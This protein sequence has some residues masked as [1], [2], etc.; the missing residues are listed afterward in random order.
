MRLRNILAALSIV[1]CLVS[2]LSFSQVASAATLHAQHASLPDGSAVNCSGYGCDNVYA[3]PEPV[4]NTNYDT[5]CGNTGQWVGWFGSE[6]HWSKIYYS[7]T[8]GT[9]WA[10]MVSPTGV[11]LK[12][13]YLERAA[14][15]PHTNCNSNP[16]TPAEYDILVSCQLAYRGCP[17]DYGQVDRDYI[18]AGATSWWTNMLYAPSPI[19]ARVCIL[20]IDNSWY[21]SDW[22]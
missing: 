8:C 10:Y 5:T 12:R 4:G 1:V 21:C 19:E 14:P 13:V 7:F 15:A 20:L 17:P 11:P 6:Q 18:P 9:N 3:Y 22:H 2:T 16:C